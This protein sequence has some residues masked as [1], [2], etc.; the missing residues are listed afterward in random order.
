MGNTIKF[1]FRKLF[2]Q[3]TFYVCAIAVLI[4]ELINVLTLF[5]IEKVSQSAFF[6]MGAAE[7]DAL[8]GF[9]YQGYMFF[10]YGASFMQMNIVFPIFITLFVCNDFSEGTI[11]NI[12]SKG[13]SRTH[14]FFS[15]LL[16]VYIAAVMYWLFGM[17]VAVV[18]GTLIWGM[19]SGFELINLAAMGAQLLLIL[20]YA[21]LDVFITFLFRK[22]AASLATGIALSTVLTLLA[23]LIDIFL[24]QKG[25]F[26]LTPYLIST[27]VASLANGVLTGEFVAWSYVLALGYI[28]VLGLGGW[29]VFR[30]KEV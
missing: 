15:K 24:E 11:K 3:K 2:R 5:L 12:L 19:G 23:A 10:N 28:A 29:L 9:G 17:L 7:I 1:E 16:T 21:T 4:V 26:T 6:A 18:T 22:K 14:V 25:S 30:K 8:G 13:L 20:G 27:R